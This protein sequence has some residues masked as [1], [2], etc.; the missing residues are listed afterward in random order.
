MYFIVM[1]NTFQPAYEIHERYDLKVSA[2][3]AHHSD[4]PSSRF[5]GTQG[6]TVGRFASEQEKGANNC[7][8]K[9]L[10]IQVWI[11]QTVTVNDG[12]TD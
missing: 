1:D 6:S 10:D 4:I 3:W 8:L 9:D 2:L 5:F 12:C 7:I 11:S